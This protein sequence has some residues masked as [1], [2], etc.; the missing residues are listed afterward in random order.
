MKG[1]RTASLS[2][3][4]LP[5]QERSSRLVADILQAAA[6]VLRSQGARRFTTARVAD[7]AGISVGSLYQYFPNKE[8]ILFRLQTDEWRETSGLLRGLLE[9]RS[10]PPAA[11]LRAMVRAFFRSECDEA[12][13]R[14]ALGDAAPLYRDAEEARRHRTASMQHMRRFMREVLPEAASSDRL[15]AADVVTISLAAIGKSVSEDGRPA[16]E[17]DRM[18]AAAAD[19]FCAWLDRLA[20]GRGFDKG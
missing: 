16:A 14:L 9:D 6:E 10:R 11:R 7:R 19:M 8:A 2:S 20:R 17:V 5:K 1:N 4:K 15:R 12:A 13:L 18:A 3:R